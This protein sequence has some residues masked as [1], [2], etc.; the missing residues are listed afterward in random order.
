LFEVAEFDDW[1]AGTEI[2]F[3]TVGESTFIGDDFWLGHAW[4]G[5]AFWWI[6][7]N[8]T[9]P[10]PRALNLTREKIEG[11]LPEWCKD[12][13]RFEDMK[14]FFRRVREQINSPAPVPS[15]EQ[16]ILTPAKKRAR[17]NILDFLR[18]KPKD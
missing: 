16:P 11:L 7:R 12:P 9:S 14:L 18:T 3:C 15:I 8:G 13:S 10:W 2:S 5:P 1:D 17:A 6:E 4:F